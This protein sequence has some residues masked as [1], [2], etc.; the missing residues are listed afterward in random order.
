MAKRNAKSSG[1]DAARPQP[2]EGGTLGPYLASIRRVRQLTLREVEEA[3]GGEVSNA[4]LSQV[5]NSKI[6]RPS[7]NVLHALARVL[8]VPYET[9]MQKAG[10]LAHAATD[11][12]DD[13]LRSAGRSRKVRPT[14]LDSETIT[15]EEEVALLE[16]LAFLRSRKG[17]TGNKPS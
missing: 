8:V 12:G 4:Y 17:G 16:Y 9:L 2:A 7:P 14:A 6:T 3:T 10:Y 13:S 11:E 15:A 5:E 1:Q